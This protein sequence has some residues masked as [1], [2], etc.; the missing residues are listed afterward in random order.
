MLTKP[1]IADDSVIACVETSFGLR[2]SAI[3][4]LPLGA[5]INSAVYRVTA[6]QG[7]SYLLKLRRGN[8][9]PLAAAVPA[10]LHTYGIPQVMA[11]I[12]T[13]TQQLWM[14]A[15]GF[16]WM[17]YP[18]F[19]GQNGYEVAL[20]QAQ[21]RALGASMKAV[22]SARLPAELLAHVR[23]ED[24]SPRRRQM[25]RAFEHELEQRLDDDPIAA[26]FASFWISKRAEIASMVERAEQLAH[27][28]QQR[29]IEL[30]LCH[31]DFHAGNVL[32]GADDALTI[33]DWD[34]VMLAPKE[35]D[36]MSV[37]AGL[38]GGWN[39]DLEE[40]W[41]YAGYGPVAIDPAV[42]AYYRYERI[43]ADIAAYA[44]QVFGM[45]GSAEDREQ[46]LR[47]WMYQF[48]PNQ[49]V[50]LAHTSYQQLLAR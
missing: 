30:V 13:V 21:W 9:D 18:F 22:H 25:V 11:P 4:F 6:D 20:S 26:R 39:Q 47:Q 8:F 45:E 41:F 40:A 43:V 16:D 38:F 10:L 1:D 17:L 35:R 50:E 46:G 15:H 37:G 3:T 29:A 12:A 44:A 28:L 14:R 2:I 32:A 24:Y 33:I 23:Q 48:R 36:L 34:E 5:D 49:V 19:E 27:T 7:M 42:L 31:A